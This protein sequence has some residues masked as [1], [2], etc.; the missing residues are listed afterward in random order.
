MRLL[1]RGG[2]VIDTEPEVVA[3]RAD[4]LIEDGRI[5][6]VGPDLIVDPSDL[7]VIDASERIVLPGFVD[8]HR[9]LWQTALRGVTVDDD[10][11]TYF[12]RVLG[13]YGSKFR[14]ED[15][16]AGNLMG[17]LE[18][19]DAG[20]TTVQDYSHVQTSP[21]HADAALDAL[22]RSGIRA[23][24]GYGPSPLG[25]G[26][27]DADEMRRI[28]EC[29]SDRIGL[30]VAAIG[31]SFTAF[32]TVRADWELADSLGLPV[33]VHIS[34]SS[35]IPDPITRLRDAG[36]LRPNTLYVHGNLL[37]DSELKLIAESGA[38]VSATP[39]VEARMEMGEPLAGRLRAAGVNVSLGIDVVTSAGGSMFTEMHELLAL[40]YKT[41]TAA[42]VLRI[43]T[44][45]GARALGLTDVGSLAVGNRAD[46]V[47]L[48][49]TD[50]NLA[51]GLRNPIATVVTAAHPGNVD[52][53]LVG[54]TPVKRDGKLISTSL[55]AAYEALAEST[56]YLTA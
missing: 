23:V 54:G 38:S 29:R 18:C 56:A 17:A 7:E 26:A 41:F 45:G 55:P 33:V 10:L 42:D 43:A 30:A 31:P 20:I 2:V 27:V 4:V 50:I 34:S 1:L 16:A 9:H 35:Q 46:L 40:G 51:G 44:V 15:V 6:A 21:A 13:S 24:F 25:G 37:P 3:R 47:L 28:M 14:P 36:L 19:L 12:D 48:R 5:A 32:E 11:G 49:H 8:T 52:T 53:V 22:E 39:T